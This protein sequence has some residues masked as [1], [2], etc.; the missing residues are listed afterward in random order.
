MSDYSFIRSPGFH[1]SGFQTG[2]S[3]ICFLYFNTTVR[4][5]LKRFPALPGMTGFWRNPQLLRVAV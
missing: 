1:Q 4:V 5:N 3:L 2:Q